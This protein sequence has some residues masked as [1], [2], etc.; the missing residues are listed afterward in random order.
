[1]VIVLGGIVAIIAVFVGFIISTAC[2][3]AAMAKKD[4]DLE[5]HEDNMLIVHRSMMDAGIT[6]SQCLEAVN[7]MQNQGILFRN[8]SK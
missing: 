1:V 4:N 8:R 5:A 7:Q 2:Y 6:K 3:G